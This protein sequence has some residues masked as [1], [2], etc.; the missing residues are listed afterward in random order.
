MVVQT[1]GL[2]VGGLHIVSPS[3]LNDHVAYCMH[4]LP[5]RFPCLILYYVAH[6]K[7]FVVFGLNCLNGL[8]CKL[9]L[10]PSIL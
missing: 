5:V 9:N 6:V 4:Y 1:S 10:V 3:I 8:L 2:S 7:L